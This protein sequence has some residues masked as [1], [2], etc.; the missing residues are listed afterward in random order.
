MLVEGRDALLGKVF[1]VGGTVPVHVPVARAALAVAGTAVYTPDEDA[2]FIA[3]EVGVVRDNGDHGK[4]VVL[5]LIYIG[6]RDNG[7]GEV[8]VLEVAQT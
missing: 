2:E 3:I 4:R 8:A 6:T 5:I 7:T 1:D